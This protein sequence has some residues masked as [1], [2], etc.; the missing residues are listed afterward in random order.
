MIVKS[1]TPE[2]L[3]ALPDSVSY[4]LV[5]GT[6]VERHMGWE[7]SWIGGQIIRRLNAHCSDK[8]LGWVAQAD[9]GYQCFPDRP[10]LVRKPDVSF[11]RRG[12]LPGEQLPRGH[13]TIPPDL[14]VEVISPND[15]AEEIEEKLSEYLGVGVALVW[16]I[17]PKTRTVYVYRPDGTANRLTDRQELSGEDVVPGFACPIRDLFPPLAPPAP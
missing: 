15:E 17:Y 12:R 13:C 16:V 4:E 5:D 11:L 1:V 9:A 10:K 2:D 6:L 8:N 7:S 3:L 14:A